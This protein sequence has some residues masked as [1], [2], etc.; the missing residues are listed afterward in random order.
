MPGQTLRQTRMT[1]DEMLCASGAHMSCALVVEPTPADLSVMTSV[2][3]AL[4]Y[5]VV[6]TE[7]FEAAKRLLATKRPDLLI[8]SVRLGEYNGLHLIL[9][10]KAEVPG[11]GAIVTSHVFDQVLAT[12]AETMQATFVVL[13]SSSGDL[14]AAVTRTMAR[15]D[16]STDPIR[17][18]FERRQQE[19]RMRPLGS[20]EGP[21]RRSSEDRR[22]PIRIADGAHLLGG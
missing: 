4:G 21:N 6:P 1:A 15:R 18:P 14:A 12:E 13:P 19:R 7:T 17:P 3:S 9:R 22:R 20:F 16:A 10:G 2:L 5:H 11:L 8:T